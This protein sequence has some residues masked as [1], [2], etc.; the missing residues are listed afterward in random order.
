MGPIDPI[1]LVD[2]NKRNVKA[3]RL[4]LDAIKTSLFPMFW[5]RLMPLR[6]G[7]P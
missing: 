4:L 7:H 3:K 5:E 1:L 6:C 2:F